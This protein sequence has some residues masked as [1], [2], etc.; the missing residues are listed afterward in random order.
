MVICYVVWLGSMN[1]GMGLGT[2][3]RCV[4]LSLVVVRMAIEPKYRNISY[5][6]TD[7]YH[8]TS[9]ILGLKQ[10]QRL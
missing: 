2:M 3:A 8:N 1:F 6:Y 9:L 10:A 4:V 7:T 5:I